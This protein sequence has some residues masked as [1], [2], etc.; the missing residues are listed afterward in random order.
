[1]DELKSI[2][3]YWCMVFWETWGDIGIFSAIVA[4]GAGMTAV[5]LAA[6]FGFAQKGEIPELI[7]I[8]AV[9]AIAGVLLEFFIKFF[10]ITPSKIQGKC[11]SHVAELEE[12]I[13]AN[14]SFV[15]HGAI[16][17]LGD[18]HRNVTQNALNHLKD[19]KFEMALDYRVLGN[20]VDKTRKNLTVFYSY[21]GENHTKVFTEE[22]DA[23]AR[24]P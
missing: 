21:N 7:F 23:V 18:N 24:L 4:T 13:K 20:V 12:K 14:E 17:G 9:S 3:R 19:G 16:W 22:V 5:L 6:H 15:I 1:M 10:F 8:I 11:N 2:L